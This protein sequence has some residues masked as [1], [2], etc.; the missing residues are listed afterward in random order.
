MKGDFTRLTFRKE[1][2]YSSVRRQQGR[3]DLDADWNEQADI[4]GYL[5]E[6][7]TRDVIG[8]CG[9]PKHDAGFSVVDPTALSAAEKSAL[10]NRGVLPLKSGDFLIGD[11]R[12][13][14][15]GI[16][17]ENEDIVS[18]T[19]QPDL[20][21]DPLTKSRR[22]CVYLDVWQRHLTALDDPEIREVALGGPDTATR[23]KTVWQVLGLDVGNAGA[24]VTC[25]SDVQAW[26]DAIAPS[27]IKLS[28]QAA[29]EQPSDKPCILP[30]G[31]GYRRLENQLYRVEIHD[32]GNLGGSSAPTFKWSR[33]NGC[34]VA[35][36]ASIASNKITLTAPGKDVALGFVEG[37]W[38]ELIDDRN[39][40][41]GTPGILV[42]I[43]TAD[44]LVLTVDS[45][46]A[47]PPGSLGSF[48]PDA[49]YYPKARRWDSVG[50]T[51]ATIPATNDGF[52]PL[53]DGVEVKFENGTCR[54]GD[55]WV[56]PARTDHG[57]VEW[58]QDS[59]TPSNPV[60]QLP[61][62]I[63][64]HF[65]RLAIVDVDGSGKVT[66]VED[67]RRSFPPLTEID[68]CCGCCT[69]TVG[70]TD[71]AD[72]S[73]IQKAIDSLPIQGGQICVLDGT[74]PE[75][76]Q[77][78]GKQ[79]ITIIG[80]GERSVLT[81]GLSETGSELGPVIQIE[82]STNIRLESLFFNQ[83]LQSAVVVL[84]SSRVTVSNCEISMTNPASS[85]PAI[86]FQ[87]TEGLIDHNVITGL[88]LVLSRDRVATRADAPV[89]SLPSQS[90]SGIQLAGGCRRVRIL[91]NFISSVRGQGVT[92]GNLEQARPKFPI[93]LIIRGLFRNPE[94]PC[95]NCKGP[96]TRIFPP[97]SGVPPLASP[98]SLWDIIIE[99]NRIVFAGLDGIGVIGF[100][101]L[102]STDEFV[103][104]R[105]LR[106]LGN[107][108]TDCLQTAPAAIERALVDS[109]GYGGIALAD[110]SR[111]V[112]YDNVIERNGSRLTQPV[113]G[114][115]ILHGEGIDIQRNRIVGN[116]LK[117][118]G[119]LFQSGGVIASGTNLETSVGSPAAKIAP[120]PIP[121]PTPVPTP[122]PAPSPSV[123]RQGGIEI[124]F[125]VAPVMTMPSLSTT[126]P[127]E[128]KS[129][130]RTGEPTG[131]PALKVYDNIV[132]SPVGPAL[133]A[134]AL[135]PVS[136]VGN[137]FTSNGISATDKASVFTPATVLLLNL[138]LSNEWYLQ[139]LLF[140]SIANQ[141]PKP[142]PGLDDLRLGSRLAN[143]N[144][145]FS[146]NQC[147]L[148]LL[149][150]RKSIV[151]SSIVLLSLDD[152]GFHDNQCD[153]DLALREDHLN[154]HAFIFAFSSRMTG[155]RLK[156]G[157]LNAVYSAMTTAIL[158]TTAFNQATHCLSVR[159]WPGLTHDGPNTI[160]FSAQCQ[161]QFQE[162]LG[163]IVAM[164]NLQT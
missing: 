106:I 41:N 127:I 135:G 3:V 149:D 89:H 44:E 27:T 38:I 144:I 148:N 90:A 138:G 152:V 153:C 70:Q 84:G 37:Q 5:T 114:V 72:F 160:L 117:T 98:E 123:G 20:L 96:G 45:T 33:D 43:T 42:P 46:Q 53:E 66:F 24:A 69:K 61:K 18:F 48:V 63:V 77:I 65:C 49:M 29:Q 97:P 21:P 14:I 87:C 30:P 162:T 32:G 9:V 143:G 131:S 54:T 116:G 129:A 8:A 6:T 164:K 64:H 10:T 100:F 163:N 79:N 120:G 101:D 102:S 62:G 86:F 1:K 92:L 17:C 76:V 15:D 16:L 155:N 157:A 59:A 113:C 11:G 107:E 23:T 145:L 88:G 4:S 119:P 108:I 140:A 147:S 7:E 118:T 142:S 80:C 51:T 121:T 75:S 112:I 161:R 2:H 115:F 130:P 68:D 141:N 73:S 58:P 39:E 159:G 91:E 132:G 85:E 128:L 56:I 78:K 52:L 124:V 83:G 60:P 133:S 134:V 139:E 55:Y 146:D 95:D 137:Q 151:S 81:A 19:N 28:A 34:V 35:S 150:G 158:N 12:A 110:V 26:D 154:V 93:G 99:K 94:D 103:S 71:A 50:V 40:W 22:Y 125:A 47:I 156:E 13:Y 25:A 136:I 126:I 74:Y 67:C 57:D 109:M 104:V 31:A 105:G 36:I 82:N 122:A 111:L